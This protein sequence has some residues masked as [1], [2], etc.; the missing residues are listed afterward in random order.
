MPLPIKVVRRAARE[1][2]EAG[3]WWQT[4][5]PAAPT[6]IEEELRR[7]F[8][9]ISEHPTVGARALNAKLTGVHRIYLSRIRYHVYYRVRSEPKSIEVLAF[10]HGSRGSGPG[11]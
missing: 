10:W 3:E 7:A 2:A 9:L 11:V 5:R 6:A 1:I 8:A 4:N